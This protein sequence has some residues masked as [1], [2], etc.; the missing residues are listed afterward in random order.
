[1]NQ[2]IYTYIYIYIYIYYIILWGWC[3]LAMMKTV[4]KAFVKSLS[5]ASFVTSLFDFLD[6]RCLSMWW[7]KK[8]ITIIKSEHWLKSE[9][10]EA[11]QSWIWEYGSYNNSDWTEVSGCCFESHLGELFIATSKKPS[12]VHRYIY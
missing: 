6:E 5:V 9:I 10:G 1:M 7:L 3:C 12:V 2:Y 4:W 11:A 8:T